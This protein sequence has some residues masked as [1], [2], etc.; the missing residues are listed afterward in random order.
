MIDAILKTRATK[1]CTAA[2]MA[3]MLL[4]AAPLATSLPMLSSVAWADDDGGREGAE[5]S[6]ESH[7]A[8]SGSAE[9]HDASSGAAESHEASTGSAESHDTSSGA[10]E[11]HGSSSSERSE[12]A[13]HA[14]GSSREAADG[15]CHTLFCN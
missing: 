3:A 13:D 5:A 12:A 7:E 6:G 8:S 10:S 9:S 15:E 14:S 2:A 11:S 4:G 1:A